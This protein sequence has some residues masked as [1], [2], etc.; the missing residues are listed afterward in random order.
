MN[1]YLWDRSGDPDPDV[2]RIERL[3]RPFA[4]AV[5]PPPLSLA[6]ERRVSRASWW[7]GA[8]LLAAT[9]VIGVGGLT[10]AFRVHPAAPSWQVTTGAGQ[11]ALSVGSWL[12]TGAGERASVNVADIGQLLVEPHTRLRLLNTRSGHHSLELARGTMRATIWAPPNQFFVE[13]P[14]TLAVD[15]GC[16]YTLTVDDEGA[17]L[18]NVLVGWVG[19]KWRDRESFI[20]AGSSCATRPRVGPGT[21]YN[22]RVSP[23]YREALATLDFN[24]RSADAASALTRVLGE[25]GERDEVTLW[26]LLSRVPAADRD[27]VFDRLAAFVAPPAGVTRDGIRA[28]DRQ[29]LDAWWDALGLGSTSLWRKWSQQWREP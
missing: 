26:H 25:S 1:D 22:D 17:G 20:P 14:S 4:Q 24:P 10:L 8:A 3:L 12:E 2:E 15:L 19:F 13:T 7:I 9:L 5:P 11:S 16:S 27:R 18:V 21:P 29:M 23:Q 28:G 6:T